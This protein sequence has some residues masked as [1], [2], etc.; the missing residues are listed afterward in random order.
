M[1]RLFLLRRVL[2]ADKRRKRV[3]GFEQARSIL[4]LYELMPDNSHAFVESLLGEIRNEGK[5]ITALGFDY[6]KKVSEATLSDPGRLITRSDFAW[7]MKPRKQ[8]LKEITEAHNCDILL[9]LSTH[10][11]IQMKF[12]AA[13]I[14]APYKVGA[15][16]PD[17]L[18]IYDLILEVDS[19]C[20]PKDLAQHAIHYLKIIKTP[21]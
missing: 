13:S 11:A 17:F 6:R 7:T 8:L 4:V 12:L 14:P 3:V 2:R 19:T 21:Q 5:N 15:A 18:D 1:F 20:H 10:N 16:H 9:D